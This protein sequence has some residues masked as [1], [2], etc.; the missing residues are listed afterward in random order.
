M[1]EKITE[2]QAPAKFF[3]IKIFQREK[4]RESLHV[5]KWTILIR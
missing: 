5:F 4:E 3:E 2:S 1:A